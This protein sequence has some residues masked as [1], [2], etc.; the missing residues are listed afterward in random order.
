MDNV[1][2][3]LESFKL[4]C[5]LPISGNY[6]LNDFFRLSRLTCKFAL[7]QVIVCLFPRKSKSPHG[8]CMNLLFHQKVNLY[9][10]YSVLNEYCKEGTLWTCHNWFG[11][12]SYTFILSER[13]SSKYPPE[14]NCCSYIWPWHSISLE[15]CNSNI[16]FR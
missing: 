5:Y 12:F 16:F 13:E 10:F 3:E 1:F 2:S 9:P 14:N 11:I 15:L 4:P 7:F 8:S 6:Y